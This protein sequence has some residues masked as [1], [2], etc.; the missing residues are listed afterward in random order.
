MVGDRRQRKNIA[1]SQ[2]ATCIVS[3]GNEV[4]VGYD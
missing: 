2:L 4:I 3:L 1:G